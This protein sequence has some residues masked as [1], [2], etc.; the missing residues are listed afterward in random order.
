MVPSR[1]GIKFVDVGDSELSARSHRRVLRSEPS[2]PVP[3][4]ES[5]ELIAFRAGI[6]ENEIRNGVFQLAQLLRQQGA[7]SWA[8]EG[9]PG[10]VPALQKI[11]G[12]RMFAGSRFHGAND[13]SLVSDRGTLGHELTKMDSGN[14]SWDRPERTAGGGARFGIP[15]FE[16]AG[17]TT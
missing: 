9:W 5:L 6:E 3:G 8:S 7:K 2:C 16:L 17:T 4:L 14:G 1:D 11:D 15:G 12:L 10:L 13:S